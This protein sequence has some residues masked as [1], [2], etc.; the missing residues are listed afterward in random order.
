[1]V[2]IWQEDLDLVGVTHSTGFSGAAFEL[3]FHRPGA[4]LLSAQIDGEQWGSGNRYRVD[5]LANE[6]P[7]II[8]ADWTPPWRSSYS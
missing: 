2:P 7:L 4:E 1:V 3:S 5:V 6:L 8:P